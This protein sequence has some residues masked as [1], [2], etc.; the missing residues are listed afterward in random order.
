M[1]DPGLGE[2]FGT[3]FW[4]QAKASCSPKS[5]LGHTHVGVKAPQNH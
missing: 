1:K 5:I 3:Q 4:P 2:A